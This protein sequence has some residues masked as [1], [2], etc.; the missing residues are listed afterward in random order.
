MTARVEGNGGGAV[1]HAPRGS[2][3]LAAIVAGERRKTLA[4][5]LWIA[6]AAAVAIAFANLALRGV[7]PVA[8]LLLAFTGCCL[9]SLRLNQ[10][11]FPGAAGILLF[12]GILA[13]T[14][15]AV[16]TGQGI[17]DTGMLAYP[18]LVIL[19]GLIFGARLL[20]PAALAAGASLVVVTWTDW[21]AV[22]EGGESDRLVDLVAVFS[23]MAAAV[24]IARLALRINE[25][26]V[27]RLHRSEHRVWV[28]YE[29]TLEAWARALEYRDRE[30]EGHTRRVTDLS[31]RMA[32][33]LGLAG[34]DLRRIRWGAML[35]DIGKLA[36]PDTILLK[37]GPLDP[38]ERALM[39][40]HPVYAR[41][42]LAQIP[43]LADCADIPCHHHERWDGAGYPDGLAGETIPFAARLFSIVDQWEALSSDR[44]YRPAWP[45]HDVVAYLR[46][47]AGSALDPSL[48]EV[49]LS[50]VMG[51]DPGNEAH[52]LPLPAAAPR[53]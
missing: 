45:R 6:I 34:D 39:N 53:G 16:F 10:K 11:G 28:A 3:D 42:M 20:L 35:H 38:A 48:V 12:L 21:R 18:I 27:Q 15:F 30:T 4:V 19:S 24:V 1:P 47:N 51:H 7:T 2:S 46:D 31:V 13:P 5:V 29:R 43:F 9:V 44:P 23:L 37:N 36:I 40:R 52:P 14:H 50:R 22:I 49:F 17:R 8:L 32:E 26:A 33:V 41:E 25:D